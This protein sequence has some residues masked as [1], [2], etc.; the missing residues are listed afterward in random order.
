MSSA[1]TS[2]TWLATVTATWPAPVAMSRT[3]WFGLRSA[4]SMNR[5]SETGSEWEGLLR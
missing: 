4:I 1:T 3:L 5:A 2:R